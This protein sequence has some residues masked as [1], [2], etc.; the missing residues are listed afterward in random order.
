MFFDEPTF[1]RLLV[2]HLAFNPKPLSTGP[3]NDKMLRCLKQQDGGAS[4]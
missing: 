2:L 3:K 4:R 1:R